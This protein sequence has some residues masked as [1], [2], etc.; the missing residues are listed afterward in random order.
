M[1]KSRQRDALLSALVDFQKAQ[2]FFMLAVQA[3]ALVAVK[4]SA[5][6]EAR[7]LQEYANNVDYLPI[8]TKSGSIPVTFVL[9]TLHN[10]GMRSCYMEKWNVWRNKGSF[11]QKASTATILMG[12]E[13]G[14]LYMF[15]NHLFNIIPQTGAGRTWSFVGIEIASEYRIPKPYK[16]VK[17][18]K[19]NS[20]PTHIRSN[21]PIGNALSE[22]GMD[23]ALLRHQ[24]PS[25]TPDKGVSTEHLRDPSA[26]EQ[27]ERFNDG[28]RIGPEIL[29]RATV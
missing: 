17:F 16:V 8:I 10:A 3:A 9:F 11:I 27:P 24:R 22:A 6:F 7:S 21:Y 25:S 13:G 20:I 26:H 12:I 1:R 28:H 5:G 15:S 18:D 14:F 29:P 19:D 4:K 23:L 2:C